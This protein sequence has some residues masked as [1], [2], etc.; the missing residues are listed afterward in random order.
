MSR[1]QSDAHDRLS[2]GV[3]GVGSMGENH[4]RIYDELRSVD[5]VG[6]CD[7]D[8]DQAER[9]A[10]AFDTQA[11]SRSELLDSADLVS[12]AVPTFAHTEVVTDCIDAGTHAL[13]EK[14]FV[15]DPEDGTELIRRAEQAD[16]TIQVG[17][18]E[19]FNPAI[20]ALPEILEDLDVIAVDA[21]R[22]GPPVEGD[23][24]VDRSVVLDLMIHDLDVVTALLDSELRDVSA[25]G[26]AEGAYVS[27]VGELDD[28]VTASFTASRTT[29]RKVRRLGITARQCRVE[30]DYADRRIELHRRS[31]PT[32]VSDSGDVRHRIESVV[33]HP[34]VE[35]GEPLKAELESFV[36]T[37]ATGGDPVVTAADGLAAVETVR[38]IESLLDEPPELGVSQS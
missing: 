29:Q 26:S 7:V 25:Y 33:E 18:V 11:R 2:A 15:A 14:P 21:L 16:V 8:P 9:V 36:E 1:T 5:L 31:R 30:V 27:A 17:H 13:V 19:R 32:Y 38:R 37:V 12:V 24:G 10:D 23:R 3:I 35:N 6:V 20:R 4:A 28:G 34:M 22:L